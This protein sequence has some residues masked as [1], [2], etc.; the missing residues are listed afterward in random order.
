MVN[1]WAVMAGLTA[2][3]TVKETEAL[4]ADSTWTC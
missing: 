3:M 4:L 1:Q 2:G